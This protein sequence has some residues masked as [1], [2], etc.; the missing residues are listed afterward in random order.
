M[1]PTLLDTDILSEILKQRDNNV[2][3]AGRAYLGEW[4]R[5][6]FS[7]ITRIHPFGCFII[8]QIPVSRAIRLPKP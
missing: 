1:L 4:R 3:Q 7:V 8:S 5:F 2:L 6:T